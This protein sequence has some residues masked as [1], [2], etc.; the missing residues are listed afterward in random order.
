MITLITI[1]HIFVCLFLVI[2]VLL[3]S[4]QSC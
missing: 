3:Q 2:V 1:I 4:G